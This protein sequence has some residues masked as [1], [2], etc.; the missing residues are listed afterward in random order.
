[1]KA[2]ATPTWSQV[3]RAMRGVKDTGQANTLLPET[4]GALL[5]RLVLI[6]PAVRLA[7]MLVASAPFFPSSWR[8][9]FESFRQVLDA[10]VAGWKDD[11][12]DGIAA[13][14]KAGKDLDPV[15]SNFKAGKDL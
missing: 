10:V 7:L 2:N 5:D 13:R 4:F 14:F 11:R 1:M 6:Y 8:K 12:P 9:G 15:P 3:D